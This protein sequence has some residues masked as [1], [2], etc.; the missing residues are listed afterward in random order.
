MP[1]SHAEQYS[2]PLWIDCPRVRHTSQLIQR[3]LHGKSRRRV[4]YQ[5]G[6]RGAHIFRVGYY[7]DAKGTP[8]ARIFFP[9]YL[10]GMRVDPKVFSCFFLICNILKF[11]QKTPFSSNS[12]CF[13]TPK[14]CMLEH[15]LILKNNPHTCFFFPSRGWYPNSNKSGPP[16]LSVYCQFKM[17]A[18]QR[19]CVN[20]LLLNSLV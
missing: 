9:G 18:I 13:Y 4:V 17:S 7:P 19:S 16:G 3:T 6:G 14:R 5:P 10:P 12:G 8:E 15:R 11:D 2:W 1:V 20:T